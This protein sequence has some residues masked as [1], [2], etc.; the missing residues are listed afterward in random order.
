MLTLG[1]DAVDAS[2]VDRLLYRP[3]LPSLSSEP[4]VEFDA[5]ESLEFRTRDYRAAAVSYRELI[6]SRST[7]VRAGALLRL[8]RTLRKMDRTDEALAASADLATLRD[9]AVSG[10]RGR[11]CGAPC[12]LRAAGR[13]GT[14]ARAPQRGAGAACGSHG[15]PLA[16]R[17]WHLPRLLRADASLGRRG[18]TWRSCAR[19]VIRCCGVHWQQWTEAPRNGFQTGG[20]RARRF[21]GTSI[22]FV[23]QP[24]GDRLAVL[25]A[26]PVFQQREWFDAVRSSLGAP[27]LLVALADDTGQEAF[28]T[29]PRPDAPM[30]ERRLSAVTGL[31]WTVF[32]GSS[33]AA[34]L[35]EIAGRRRL[36]FA[37]LALLV[38]LVV[39]ARLFHHSG[40]PARA[41]RRAA[42]VGFRRSRLARIPDAAHVA[43][44]V[45]RM[46]RDEQRRTY[47][48]RSVRRSTSAVARHGA[49]AAARRV[50]SRLRPDGSWR[51]TP[52][53]FDGCPPD[54]RSR[55]VDDSA[56][57]RQPGLPVDHVEFRD[58]LRRI[59]AD[60]DALARAL[61]NL[62]DNAVKYSVRASRMSRS[63]SSA[64][65]RCASPI[66]VRDRWHRHCRGRSSGQIFQKFVRGARQPHARHQGHRHRPRHGRHIVEAHGGTVRVESAP[67]RAA[68]SRSCCRAQS[69][70]SLS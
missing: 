4:I 60:P 29:V 65:A 22:T 8:G 2:P 27:G 57:V 32:V 47:P 39:A 64:D 67:G 42:A 45:H 14:A 41:G 50:A 11:P 38:A 59:D 15:G 63:T 19:S 56:G 16:A 28:G 20:R 17:P 48:A 54:A 26:G 18:L 13:N 24:I 31:P 25:A 3:A 69:G 46:L 70:V 43:A 40:G 49:A 44:P 66:A 7:E 33:T 23:W 61:W 53:S 68:R 34:D 51:A 62:L 12:A 5:G 35:D 36:I 9:V 10:L 52:I 58:G 55:I 37:G 6:A 21:G 30:T 1:R